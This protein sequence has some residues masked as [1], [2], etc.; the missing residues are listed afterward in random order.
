MPWLLYLAALAAFLWGVTTR[1]AG[2][3]AALLI[4]AFVLMVIGAWLHLR[5]RLDEVERPEIF[6]PPRPP[7]PSAPTPPPPRTDTR[8]GRG[9]T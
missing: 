4:S 1:S 5:V 6:I 3:M 2:L 8:T 9:A 7:S